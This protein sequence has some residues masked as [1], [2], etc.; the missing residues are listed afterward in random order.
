VGISARTQLGFPV[1]MAELGAMLRPIRDFVALE[2]PHERPELIARLHS[3][4]QVV[5][6]D[7]SGEKARFRVRLPVHLRHEFHRFRIDEDGETGGNA[8]ALV[9]SGE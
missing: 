1:F 6:R 9:H 7:F 2:I 5:E 3:V 8:P 4:G